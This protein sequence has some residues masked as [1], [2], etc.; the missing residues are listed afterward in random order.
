MPLGDEPCAVVQTPVGR[1]G[2][3]VAADVFVPEVARSLMLRG[4]EILLVCAD[5]GGS[6]LAQLVRCRADENRVFVACAAAP[7]AGATMIADP[8]GRTL[9]HALEGHELSVSASV[10]RALSHLKAIAPGTDFVRDRQPSTYAA[11]T[12]RGTLAH[13]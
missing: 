11:L 12:A 10:N 2:L 9:A 3:I 7:R 6:R 8:A 4:A 1:V 13:A 5:E